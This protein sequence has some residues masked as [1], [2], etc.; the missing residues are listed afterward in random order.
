MT[1]TLDTA[2]W[3]KT[4]HPTPAPAARLVCFPHAGGSAT[5]F[6]QLSAALGP[7]VRVESVQYPGRQDR[8][9]EPLIGDLHTL[10]DLLTDALATGELPTAFFGHSM[11]ATLAFEVARRWA[12]RGT[13][14]SSLFVS[15]RR[16]PSLPPAHRVA[17]DTDADVLA[18]IR[19]LSGTDGRLLDDEEMRAMI[20]PI[21]RNDL[22]AAESY[23][24]HPG[25]DL[26]CPIIVLRGTGDPRASADEADQW[27]NHTTGP[28]S[29]H[30]FDGGHFYLDTHITEVA[31]I[32]SGHLDLERP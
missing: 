16:A 20:L 2:K 5:Y 1:D 7:T 23:T 29:T 3:Y 24:L 19:C 4:F 32:I 30:T 11:G 31:G 28:F 25:P 8:R 18:E 22:R 21:A 26:N 10:A 6:W 9:H 13:P 27:R 15:S 17:F 14:L 12:R